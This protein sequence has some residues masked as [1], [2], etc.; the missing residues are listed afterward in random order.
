MSTKTTREMF[1]EEFPIL[2]SLIE[3]NLVCKE[4][5]EYVGLASDGLLVS[6]GNIVEPHLVEK[7]LQARPTPDLW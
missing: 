7:Y 1:K 6:L 5:S 4:G 3:Q 2:A